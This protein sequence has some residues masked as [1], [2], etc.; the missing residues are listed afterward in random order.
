M[1][2]IKPWIIFYKWKWL[3]LYKM[4]PCHKIIVH[5][6]KY[7]SLYNIINQYTQTIQHSTVFKSTPLYVIFTISLQGR[8]CFFLKQIRLPFVIRWQSRAHQS[9]ISVLGCILYVHRSSNIFPCPKRTLFN[10]TNIIV[11]VKDS[12]LKQIN[13]IFSCLKVFHCH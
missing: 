10:I 1:Q 13:C 5:E 8:S 11:N 6:W 3:S 2:F 7:L 9:F 12:F 4:L